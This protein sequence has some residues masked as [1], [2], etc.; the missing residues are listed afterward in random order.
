MLRAVLRLLELGDVKAMTDLFAGRDADT[1]PN[2][3]KARIKAIR[4]LSAKGNAGAFALAEVV[5]DTRWD[6]FALRWWLLK[7]AIKTGAANL[8][9]ENYT[10]LLSRIPADD[11]EGQ[12]ALEGLRNYGRDVSELDRMLLAERERMTPGKAARVVTR[13]SEAARFVVNIGCHDGKWKDPCYELYADGW[14][15][16]A[17]DAAEHPALSVNLP[18]P[19]VRKLQNTLVTPENAVRIL[20]D[21]GCP[22]HFSLLKIDIDS[23]DGPI[24]KS[25]LG[26]YAP[27]LIYIEVNPE[28]PPPIAFTV[29]FDPRYTDSSYGGFSGCSSGYVLD[30]AGPHYDL[31]SLDS[32]G[33]STSQDILLVHSDYT[34]L[35]TEN[36]A[37][38]DLVESFRSARPIRFSFWDMGVDSRPWRSIEDHREMAT[39]IWDACCNAS[40]GRFGRVL[41][42]EL[43][44]R[45]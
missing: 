43:H 12:L 34:S 19:D 2:A 1:D 21:A 28:I 26:A 20:A 24:L 37:P 13:H 16:I 29:E 22:Q 44:S 45:S 40:I 32:L 14:P 8:E 39:T 9:K 10:A 42:F 18:S 25:L 36:G 15:G 31:L 33:F 6:S 3:L 11:N 41:P 23:F 4:R 30:V 27:D 7:L 5:E 17:V 38:I 35:F